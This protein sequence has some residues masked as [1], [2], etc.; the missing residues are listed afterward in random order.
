MRNFVHLPT[1]DYFSRISNFFFLVLL[2]SCLGSGDDDSSS[3]S[4][5]S[6]RKKTLPSSL[7]AG[8]PSSCVLFDNG[9]VKCWGDNEYGQLGLGDDTDDRGDDRGEIGD[10]LPYVDLGRGRT[11]KV[12]SSGGNS[13]CAILDNDKI[14]CWGWNEYGQLG[15]GDTEGR[16]DDTGEMGDNLPY[17]DLGTGRTVKV[18]SSG[19]IHAC[20]ILDNDKIKCWGLTASDNSV[21]VM[22]PITEVTTQVKWATIFPM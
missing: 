1:P 12:L 3:S 4:G 2:A 9:A 6:P 19:D 13:T 11:V 16:G 7:S 14:K 20:A 8:P 17:V 10:N 21:S 15:L 5:G 22:I 18:L